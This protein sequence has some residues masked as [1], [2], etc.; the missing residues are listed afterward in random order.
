[1]HYVIIL[2]TNLSFWKVTML[3]FSGIAMVLESLTLAMP[4]NF[5]IPHIWVKKDCKQK[6]CQGVHGKSILF[7]SSYLPPLPPWKISQWVLCKSAYGGGGWP[8]LGNANV[9]HLFW[10]WVEKS[11]LNTFYCKRFVFMISSSRQSIYLVWCKI[12]IDN[13]SVEF[14]QDLGLYLG[15]VDDNLKVRQL[16][17][18]LAD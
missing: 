5:C 3:A 18:V 11:I 17:C 10:L 15:R 6:C 12:I 7:Q 16:S 14:T 2:S 1:M 9:A 8:P 4:L 13:V